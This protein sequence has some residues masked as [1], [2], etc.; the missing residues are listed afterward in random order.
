MV[1]TSEMSRKIKSTTLRASEIT[2]QIQEEKRTEEIQATDTRGK[3]KSDGKEIPEPCWALRDRPGQGLSG[4]KQNFSCAVLKDFFSSEQRSL[5]ARQNPPLLLGEGEGKN[6]Q[7]AG[8]RGA[9]PEPAPSPGGFLSLILP[10]PGLL[11]DPK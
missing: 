4:Q 8:A 5:S 6:Q 1:Q 9:A 2:P 11:P 10:R 3:E 7:R